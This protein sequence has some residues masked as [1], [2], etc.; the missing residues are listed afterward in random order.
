MFSNKRR[1]LR[2]APPTMSSAKNAP[3]AVL[4]LAW[5]SGENR[6]KPEHPTTSDASARCAVYRIQTA[7]GQNENR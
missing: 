6:L 3:P 5:A 4:I 7:R 2:T 1:H